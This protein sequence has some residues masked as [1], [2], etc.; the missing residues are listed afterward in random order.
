MA[1]AGASERA[2]T[3]R[4]FVALDLP[5]PARDA[6]VDWRT[7]LVQRS[8]GVLRA[9]PEEALHVTL[10]FLGSLP[11]AEIPALSAVVEERAAP[12]DGLALGAPLWLPRRRP[13]VLTVELEDRERQ[14]GALQADVGAR[15]V[16]GGWFAPEPRPFLPHVTVA[17]V[18]GAGG[19]GDRGGAPG[20]RRGAGPAELEALLADGGPP[21]PV[22]FAG[23]ALVLYR[24][25]L[26][27][28]PD[29]G[30]QY[31]PLVRVPL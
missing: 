29:G 4:L 1:G 30:S 6:L 28:G 5:D 25:H 11:E 7:P 15:L 31:E 22:T 14:L 17:R 24:S 12:A 23:A 16:E 26:G 18:R 27:R 20:G 10:C 13:R 9:V 8:G 21:P 2:P 3:A 19:R